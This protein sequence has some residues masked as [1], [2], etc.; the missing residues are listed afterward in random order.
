MKVEEK[1]KTKYPLITMLFLASSLSV[2][3][4]VKPKPKPRAPA[5][6]VTSQSATTGDGKSVVL[7]SNGTW[8]YAIDSPETVL[9]E[10]STRP[11]GKANSILSFET[12]LVFK[13][14]D[15]KPVARATFYLLDD[16]LAKIL[17]TAGLVAPRNYSGSG[18]TDEDLVDAYASSIKYRIMG[19]YKEFGP[20]AENAVRPHI[21][22]T[23]TTGFDGKATFETVAAGTYY[24]MGMSETPKGYVIWNLKV[25]LK[26]GKNFV[27]LDQNNAVTAI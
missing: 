8:K 14:G 24:L 27:T 22:Q 4:Q 25:E 16:D 7:S 13:S 9:S 6:T 11:Q 17:R 12:G 1:M 15:V 2:Y 5:P 20:A 10:P 3:G 19:A 21:I 18:N 26:P 23:I